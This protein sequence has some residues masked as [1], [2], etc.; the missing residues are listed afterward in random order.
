[1]EANVLIH[2]NPVIISN[3][4]VTELLK[5]FLSGKSK[6]TLIAYRQD[7]EDF[8]V[9]T[10]SEDLYAAAQLLLSHRHGKANT[11]AIAYRAAMMERELSPAT[12]NRRL[13]AIRSLVKL[14]RTLGMVPWTLE[15]G[16]LKAESYRNTA[17]PGK[18]GVHQMISALDKRSDAKTKRD[19]AA[20]RLLYDLALRRGETVAL[21]LA[22]VDLDASRLFVC[23]KGKMEKV[24]LT[25]PKPTKTALMEWI[26]ARGNEPGPL[27]LNF[28]HAGKGSRLTGTSLYRIVRGLGV[29]AGFKVRP[30]GLRHTA[31][32]EACKQASR[33]GIGL[34]E[35]RNFSGHAD[36]RT[37]MIY[38]DRERNVQGQ[39]AALVAEGV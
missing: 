17:G 12:I 5:A 14:A 9:F 24:A 20:V 18:Q 32:T 16:N 34:E 2:A 15:V 35:V 13:A 11:L 6:R 29:R 10:G 30:H 22:D 19:L 28:D 3:L 8:R 4:E 27:F 7:L 38:R 33:I 1:M 36:V 26:A 39:L 25:L 21:D 37:L 31:I 23:R